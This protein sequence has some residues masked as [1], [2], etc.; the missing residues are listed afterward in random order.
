MP[1]QPVVPGV[2]DAYARPKKPLNFLMIVGVSVF[3]LA[4]IALGGLYF[5]KSIV[6]ASNGDKKTKVEEAIK[7]FEPALTRELTAI[8]ARMDAGKYLLDNHKAASLLFSILELNTAQTVQFTELSYAA[9][10]DKSIELSM[11]GKAH[12]YNAVAFQS[13]VFSR[14]EQLKNPVFGSLAI[15]EKGVI[16]FSVKAGLEPSAVMYRKLI[17]PA[18]PSA[19]AVVAT[20]SV[21]TSSAVSVA[22]TSSVTAV[23]SVV[24]ASSTGASSGNVATSTP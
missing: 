20:S 13:D 19:G 15:D 18:A 14:I 8:K 21:A 10:S 24:T 2:G 7:N 3:V 5:Y 9:A 22:T 6:V 4:G 12:S 1:R 11:K 17:Q 23:L 16:S